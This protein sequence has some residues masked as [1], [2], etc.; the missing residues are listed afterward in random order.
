MIAAAYAVG[1]VALSGLSFAAYGIDKRRSSNGGRRVR[2]RTLHLMALAGGW[3]GALLGQRMFRHKTKKVSFL[4]GFWLTV[5]LHFVAVGL[6]AL[7][8]T[9]WP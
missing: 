5:I 1:V 7:A 4:V 8:I 2:E 9:S 3:P 6:L